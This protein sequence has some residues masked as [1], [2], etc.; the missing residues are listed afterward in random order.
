MNLQP[1]EMLL[2]Y[3]LVEQIGEGGMGVVWKAADTKLDR[4]VAIKILPADVSADADRLARFEREAKSLAA[5]NHPNVAQVHGLEHAGGTHFLVMELVPGEDLA[6]RVARGRLPQTEA[7]EVGVQIA[8]AL[9]VAH[10]RG[11][12]HRDLKPA[13]VRLTPDGVVWMK[14]ASFHPC[15]EAPHPDLPP[16]GLV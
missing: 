6:Q 3:R 7:L 10:E 12:V 2:H 11:I 8:A 14:P 4:D 1:G 13:N 15:L 5:L 16:S 9:E